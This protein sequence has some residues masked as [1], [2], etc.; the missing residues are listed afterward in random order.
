[1]SIAVAVSGGAD[2]LLALILLKEQG[3]DPVALHGFFLRPGPGEQSV[4]RHLERLCRSLDVPLH[5][6]ELHREFR[7][8]VIEPFVQ[9]Y[10]RGLT[11]NPCAHCNRLVKFGLLL[12]R[13]LA[14]GASGLATGHY[15]RILAHD[16]GGP[17]LFRGLDPAKEQ[18][19]FLALLNRQQIAGAS[20]PLGAWRKDQVLQS[21]RDRGIEVPTKRESQ[22]VCFLPD[23]DYRTFLEDGEGE[24]PGPGP[25]VNASGTVLGEHQG[26]YRYTIGQRQGLGIAHPHPLYV[27]EKIWEENTLLVGAKSELLASTCRIGDLNFLSAPELWP[28]HL[29]VQTLYR[30]QARPATLEFL[31]P[32]ALNIQFQDPVTRPA[33][34]QVAAFYLP[35]GRLVGGGIIQP[36][37]RYEV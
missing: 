2:S 11:P 32:D 4:Y 5:G 30:Q 15:A 29:L 25:I 21:L 37:C 16:S 14:L 33:P 12:D 8:R 7:E 20:F 22:E 35:S 31:G 28:K 18:S 1:M 19:Y 13:A 26:L 9:D 24:L 10:C 3:L 6:L 23:N 34:G 27:R 36:E 17:A